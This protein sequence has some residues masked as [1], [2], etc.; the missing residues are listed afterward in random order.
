[1][2]PSSSSWGKKTD[3]SPGVLDVPKSN[4]PIGFPSD[5]ADVAKHNKSENLLVKESPT[6]AALDGVTLTKGLFATKAFKKGEFITSLWGYYKLKVSEASSMQVIR[7]RQNV[8]KQVN[9]FMKI[10]ERCAAF[11]INS[12]VLHEKTQEIPTNCDLM[13]TVSYLADPK[14]IGVF[15]TRDIAPGDEFWTVYS[16]I[17]VG[18]LNGRVLNQVTPMS[19]VNKQKKE[20]GK[21]PKV[22][23]EAELN[24]TDEGEI[25]DI[26]SSK[27][28]EVAE[29]QKEDEGEIEDSTSSK[30]N[31]TDVD[32]TSSSSSSS[33]SSS[34]T[35]EQPAGPVDG[36]P[37]PHAQQRHPRTSPQ[38]R[39][40]YFG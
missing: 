23:S 30:A 33:S 16:D 7:M 40:R 6:L 17:C 12:P 34:W 37:V 31:K 21:S 9:L 5:A 27:A 38:G 35:A 3:T 26:T 1:M 19:K 28:T 25:E 4:K 20:Q 36:F 10:N 13:E 15:A 22:R 39:R 11:Y 14:K 32:P 8:P 24:K 2:R 18:Q 29:G